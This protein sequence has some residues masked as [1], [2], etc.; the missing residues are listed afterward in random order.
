[1][2]NESRGKF[3]NFFQKNYVA[4]LV[5]AV[6]LLIFIPLPKFL[7][8]LLM[9]LNLAGSF[10]VLLAVLNTPRA[11]DFQ[12]FPR[13]ILI[14]TMFGLGINVASTR[15]ILMNNG[16]DA[17]AQSDMVQAFAKI[18]AGDRIVIGFVIFIIL[19]VVQVLVVTKGSG[20]VSEV[21]ARFSLD[22]MTQKFFDV[23]NRLNS[24]II[25]DQEAMRL[26]D[27]IRKEIDFYSNMDGSSK[28]VSGSVKAGIFITVVNLLG[29]VIV[30]VVNYNLDASSAFAQYSALTIGDG[31]MSQLP[32]LI[33]S[34][35][36]G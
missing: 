26:K 34:F 11:S 17:R 30:G 20:R 25:D 7:I 14:Q 27:A 19:I 16:T 6:V 32:A 23:D 2:A 31:L 36:T 28:F 24:G 10:L 8:D 33:I 5:I 18:V 22:S 13:I 29:G 12:T 35:A 15:L 3:S 21:A 1:M 4:I 9:I